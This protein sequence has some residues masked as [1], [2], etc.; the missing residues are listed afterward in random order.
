[1]VIMVKIRCTKCDKTIRS[2]S[3]KDALYRLKVH[4]FYVHELQID[5]AED[6]DYREVLN[7]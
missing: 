5:H 7:E 2:R 1:M 4:Y 3:M 6:I